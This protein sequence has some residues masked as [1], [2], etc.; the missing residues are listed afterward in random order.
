[1]D[2]GWF[3]LGYTCG[4]N[5]RKKKLDAPNKVVNMGVQ[6]I[7]KIPN[8]KQKVSFYIGLMVG[9][10]KI[11]QSLDVIKVLQY[12]DKNAHRSKGDYLTLSVGK[13]E[14]ER[15]LTVNL[16]LY[17]SNNTV[18]NRGFCGFQAKIKYNPNYLTL[19]TITQS[20]QL[21][22]TYSF[23]YQHDAI[24]GIVLIQGLDSKLSFED[25]ILCYLEFNIKETAPADNVITLSGPSGTGQGSDLLTL[26]NGET[27]YI[28]PLTLEHGLIRLE[29]IVEENKVYLDPVGDSS[30][31]YGID[32]DFSYDF[33]L[34]LN[35]VGNGSGT[36]GN[37]ADF[38]IKITFGDGTSQE[39]SI[40]LKEGSHHYSGKV[41][42]KLP[43]ISKGPV[44]IEYYVKPK[45]EDDCYYWF[46]KAG[47]LW[48]FETTIPREE[49]NQMPIIEPKKRIYDLMRLVD[50]VCIRAGGEP[51]PP[52]PSL[53]YQSV[54]D[55]FKL[56]DYV[57]TG[58]FDELLSLGQD[59]MV[60]GDFIRTRTDTPPKPPAPALT[61]QDII[62]MLNLIDYVEKGLFEE[63]EKSDV[64][65]L[66]LGDNVRIRTE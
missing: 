1:M 45:D 51:L 20:T 11:V 52:T 2:M 33:D 38:I 46:I 61:S 42:L 49:V 34:D 13:V 14:S 63:I 55:L 27:Y 10:R 16:P 24:N 39:I 50:Y 18:D 58:A 31:S 9:R 64:D 43:T 60:I 7:K 12:Q 66:T 28:M 44:L 21:P 62:E 26:I 40:P 37:G 30:N 65:N 29:G 59:L 6:G 48:G 54:K 5:S 17:V 23:T 57:K 19:N 8:E 41:P 3:W 4:V 35:F 56:V 53:P 22:T 15:G 47:A 32:T 36:G 25:I